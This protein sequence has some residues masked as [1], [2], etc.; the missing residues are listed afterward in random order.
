[1]EVKSKGR[2]GGGGDDGDDDDDDDD[3]GDVAGKHKDV[4]KGSASTW[5]PPVL[6]LLQIPSPKDPKIKFCKHKDVESCDLE[7]ARYSGC[8]QW[9]NVT[10]L[11]HTF[12][13]VKDKKDMLFKVR[14]Q[15]ADLPNSAIYDL[16]LKKKNKQTHTKNCF[17]EFASKR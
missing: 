3:D 8:S 11:S 9:H 1:M 14:C 10:N 16:L 2:G 17:A 12:W 4:C 5:S 13:G 6:D 7:Q 15:G